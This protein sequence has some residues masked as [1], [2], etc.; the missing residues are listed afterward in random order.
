MAFSLGRQLEGY[1]EI[2]IDKLMQ[3]ISKDKYR[4]KTIIIEV[5]NSYL[6]THR[7]VKE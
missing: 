6:F 4:L 5:V 3:K 2:V 1:D 7:R